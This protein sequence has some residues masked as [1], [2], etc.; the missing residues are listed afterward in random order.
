MK[1]MTERK[2]DAPGLDAF[3]DAAREE[4]PQPSADFLSRMTEEA[5]DAQL[6]QSAARRGT[7]AR[8]AAGLWRQFRQVLGGWPGIAGL[9]AACVAGI[10]LGVSPPAGLSDLLEADTA[11]LGT[12]GLDPVSAYDLAMMEG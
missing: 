10:W 12:L 6:A 5:L 2:D 7:A 11:G 1:T 3:F 9:T 8:G 4:A